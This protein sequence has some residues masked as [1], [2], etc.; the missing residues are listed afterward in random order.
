MIKVDFFYKIHHCW[1][2]P[3]ANR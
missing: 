3:R 1:R 2:S